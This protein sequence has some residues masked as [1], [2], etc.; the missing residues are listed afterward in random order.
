[1]KRILFYYCFCVVGV[2]AGRG[3]TKAVSS[4][5]SLNNSFGTHELMDLCEQISEKPAL[6]HF[7][8]VFAS[9]MC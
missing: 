2:S 8:L 7:Q 9:F 4:S 1:M 3:G 5:G 6:F